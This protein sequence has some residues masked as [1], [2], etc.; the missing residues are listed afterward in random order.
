MSDIVHTAGVSTAISTI[1]AA[2]NGLI[3][4]TKLVQSA[5][6][7]ASQAQQTA[8]ATVHTGLATGHA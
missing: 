8:D 2:N 1:Q 6:A 5:Q 7:L 4:I 3:S